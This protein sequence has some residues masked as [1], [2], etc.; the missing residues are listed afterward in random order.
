MTLEANFNKRLVFLMSSSWKYGLS[1][2]SRKRSRMTIY[3][4]HVYK[5]FINVK[6]IFYLYISRNLQVIPNHSSLFL[7]IYFI[8]QLKCTHTEFR[9]IESRYMQENIV[10]S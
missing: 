8:Q 9:H 7:S 4:V 10:K 2:D 5:L 6:I 1:V 3:L